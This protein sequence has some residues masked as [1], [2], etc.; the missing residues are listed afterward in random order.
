MTDLSVLIPARNE[1]FLARTVQCILDAIEA[2]T[3][4]IVVIDGKEAGPPVPQDKRVTT[5]TLPRAIGQRAA[6]NLAAKMS[7]AKYVMKLDAHCAIGPGFDRIMIED[8]QD[9]WT[10][11]PKMY[12]L[13]AFDWVCQECDWRI[14]Q[15]PTPEGEVCPKCGAGVRRDI[16]WQPK[17]S[18]ETTAMRFDK[19]LKFGYWSRYKRQ[20]EGD[21][22]ETM[23]LL[24]ACWMLTRDKYW[25]LSICDERH[26]GWGQQGTEVACKT[27]LS[28]GRLICNK[29][30]WFSHMF[31]TQGGDFGFP[32]RLTGHQTRRARKYSK[33]L[34]L[35]GKWEGAKY[36]L[37]WLI[38]KFSQ[39]GTIPGWEEEEVQEDTTKS[40]LYYTDN[41]LDP[42]I[43]KAC[44]EQLLRCQQVHG[45]ELISVSL[46]PI[47]FGT[48]YTYDGERGIETMFNQIWGGLD[49]CTGDV[50]YFAEHDVLYHPS[51]FDFV[52]QREDIFY[53][54]Q[55]SWRVNA[56]TGHALFHFAN[57]TSGLCAH[58]KLLLEHYARR[59]KLVAERGFS[60]RMGFE[61]GT[62]RRAER[63]DDYGCK[64]FMSAAPNIDIR[65]D[66]NLTPNRWRKDQFRNQKY[67]RGW[68]EA[69]EIPDWGRFED[70]LAEL[71]GEQE[72]AS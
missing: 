52:P 63:V 22:V 15:G 62:H 45:F 20:Q 72:D 8:M 1:M 36:P 26:G 24:G 66:K 35:D 43:M 18:P 69:D 47:Q 59:V 65:H 41:R 16:L 30:T 55:N 64:S 21:L 9:D 14:Y 17:P 50:V 58:R 12:N 57:S 61:P 49:I 23:S 68:Q 71:L 13:H 54:N 32:Y 46:E 67:T 11:V 48:N 39:D 28:G 44:Q 27:W 60:R 31:R 53:Y 56:E 29:R 70:V 4:I 38:D 37:S 2:D 33:Q 7:E 19:N 25:E 34:F 40:V 6:T 3:E 5:V 10:M 42:R 51:H